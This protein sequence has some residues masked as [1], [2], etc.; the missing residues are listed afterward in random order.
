[1]FSVSNETE[2]KDRRSTTERIYRI[3]VSF[4]LYKYNKKLS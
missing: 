4:N 3:A 2:K 1:M